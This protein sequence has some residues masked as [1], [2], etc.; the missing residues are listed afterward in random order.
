MS[1]SPED[2]F[3]ETCPD[4]SLRIWCGCC[5]DAPGKPDSTIDYCKC[6]TGMGPE[7]FPFTVIYLGN[8]YFNVETPFGPLQTTAGD[9]L[10]KH[11]LIQLLTSGE[12]TECETC[13]VA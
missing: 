5:G 13:G 1:P 4:C 12:I 6:P 7:L 3:E 9:G 10:C 11:E 8:G 2:C